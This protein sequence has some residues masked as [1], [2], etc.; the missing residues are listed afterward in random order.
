MSTFPI[1]DD[2]L[3]NDFLG[4]NT[5]ASLGRISG[6][7]LKD[8][9]LRNGIDLAFETDLLYLDVT[10]NRIGINKANPSYEL[11]VTDSINSIYVTVTEQAIVENLQIRQPDT[12][13]T[14][15]GPINLYATGVDVEFNNDRLIT[16]DLEITN[17]SITSFSNADIVLNPNGTGAVNLLKDSNITGDLFVNGNIVVDGDLQSG[18]NII[19]GDALSDTVTIAAE[20]V[21]NVVPKLNSNYTLG[22][23]LLKWN[24]S[25]SDTIQDVTA[26]TIGNIAIESPATIRST[27]G[28]INVT[29]AGVSPTAVFEK[30][31]STQLA[32][33]NDTITSKSNAN[34]LFNPNGTGTVELSASTNVTGNLYV[35]GNVSVTGDLSTA[36]NLIIGNTPYDTVTINTDFSQSIIPGT[37]NFY[38]LGDDAN[39]SSPR[40][41]NSIY[42]DGFETITNIVPL[43]INIDQKLLINGTTTSIT[44]LETNQ[45]VV[46][47]PSTGITT[48]EQTQ[49]QANDITNLLNTP[50]TFASTGIGYFK[51]TNNNAFIVPAGTTAQQRVGAE[52][53]ETRWNTEERYLECFDGTVWNVSIG[54]STGGTVSV[55]SIED[56]NHAW[57]LILG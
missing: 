3:G 33:D 28:P 50:L 5:A 44:A 47:N 41:W 53:G 45:D 4:E 14:L 21:D 8:N 20:F 24:D 11:D 46:I 37:D 39:D 9:L 35:T 49:W 38:N 32:F 48:I 17:N 36:S 52:V 55:E 16:S 6:P 7:L 15:T 40:R 10:N 26:A 22:T 29:V 43:Q 2:E 25:Y 13:S 12:F 51:F 57:T 42:S 1:G 54:P 19:V 27:T 56:L 31:E 30:L 23:S 34:I 18:D